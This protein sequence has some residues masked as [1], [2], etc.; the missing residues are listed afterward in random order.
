MEDEVYR[1]SILDSTEFV[2]VLCILFQFFGQMGD[3]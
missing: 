3:S 2:W 1:G